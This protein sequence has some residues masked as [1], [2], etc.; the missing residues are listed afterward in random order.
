MYYYFITIFDCK[1]F[2]TIFVCKYVLMIDIIFN[3][4]SDLLD[5]IIVMTKWDS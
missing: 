5:S 1:Y 4:Y 2:I 3:F